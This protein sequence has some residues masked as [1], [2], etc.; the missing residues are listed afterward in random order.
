LKKKKLFF[1][2]TLQPIKNKNNNKNKTLELLWVATPPLVN[3][4]VADTTLGASK[5]WPRPTPMGW[6]A[7]HNNLILVLEKIKNKIKS[8]KVF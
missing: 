3:L 7:T 6:P 5:G 4:G 8:C 2:L 1:I